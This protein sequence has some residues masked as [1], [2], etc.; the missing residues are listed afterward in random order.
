MVQESDIVLVDKKGLRI[1]GRKIDE[2][3]PIKMKVG[4]LDNADGS[5]LVE[6][7]NTRVLAAVYG[8]K[9]LHPQ[10][11]QDQKTGIL[12]VRYNM[13]PFS[14]SDR[15]RP[16]PNRRS[17][18][19]SLVTRKALEDVIYLKEFP[20]TTIKVYIEVLEANASTR[21]TGITAASLALANAG[22]PMKNMVSACAVGKAGGRIILDVAGKEDSYGEAD[23]PVAMVSN[24]EEITLLQVDSSGL[25]PKELKQALELA[26]KGC[27]ILYEEQ[28]KALQEKYNKVID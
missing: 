8:P 13:A 22:V 7:G 6:I 17:T 4:V 3:R 9:E 28:K 14:T 19:I 15:I 23:I 18:E 10:H 1:D 25:S 5:A 24:T 16:G 27:K 21:A 20:M 26:Q 11:L 2:M 12:Q